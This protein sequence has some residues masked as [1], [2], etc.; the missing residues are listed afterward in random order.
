[1]FNKSINQGK[2]KSQIKAELAHVSS[3]LSSNPVD[4]KQ[5]KGKQMRLDQMNFFKKKSNLNEIKTQLEFYFGDPN[6]MNDKNMRNMIQENK[7]GYVSIEKF[8][9]FNRIKMLLFESNISD[10]KERL[11]ILKKSVLKSKLLKLN[12]A[13]NKVKR[14][15]P[16][17]FS[18]LENEEFRSKI[19][20]RKIFIENLFEETTH[21][22]LHQIFS[23]YGKILHVSIPKNKE[24]KTRGF[25]FI[26]FEVKIF[27]FN[28]FRKK[29]TL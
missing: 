6:L 15:I 21:D 16:F 20:N 12:K 3:A 18:R 23:V 7:K 14:K 22:K 9:N 29:N 4:S 19:L 10:V 2:I 26:E 27:S 28:F 8:L 24:K 13:K 25:A 11:K 17:D 1:M 5:K